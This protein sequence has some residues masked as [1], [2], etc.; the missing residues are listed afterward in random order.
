MNAMLIRTHMTEDF[1]RGYFIMD[2]FVRPSLELPW[3]D[4]TRNVSCIPEGEYRCDVFRSERWDKVYEVQNVPGRSAILF[5][6]GNTTA[7]IEGCILL[8]TT[9]GM[10]PLPDGDEAVLT[11]Q[12]AIEEMFDHTSSKP[13]WLRVVNQ[14]GG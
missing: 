8:G 3:R 12:R 6:P 5:H 2:G 10:L 1:A 11:S 13:F 7:D 4:N 9:R 14:G